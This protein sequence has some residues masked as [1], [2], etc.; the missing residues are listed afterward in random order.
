[1]VK[2]DVV[3]VQDIYWSSPTIFFLFFFFFQGGGV[4]SQ[5]SSYHEIAEMTEFSRVTVTTKLGP[6]IL[7]G[8][9]LLVKANSI[10]REATQPQAKYN[11]DIPQCFTSSENIKSFFSD[12]LFLLQVTLVKCDV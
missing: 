6:V 10:I 3:V 11:A 5:T 9:L 7:E 12:F 8:D 2:V 1:M 4:H